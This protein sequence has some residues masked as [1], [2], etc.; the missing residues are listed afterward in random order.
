MEVNELFKPLK[1][2]NKQERDYYLGRVEESERKMPSR[3]TCR[4]ISFPTLPVSF[5]LLIIFAAFFA[6]VLFPFDPSYMALTEKSL[7]PSSQHWF[8]TDSLGRDVFGM[9]LHGARISLLIG[10]AS[11]VISMVM[12]LVVGGS[13][14]MLPGFLKRILTRFTDICLSVPSI[15]LMI[16]FQGIMRESTWMSISL[17]IGLSSWM[18]M[19]KMIRT[20][21]ERI[22]EEEY[23]LLARYYGGGLFYLLKRHFSQTLLPVLSYMS[24]TGFG[25]AITAEATL[26]FL[27]IGLPLDTITWGTL[28]H[29]SSQALMTKAWWVI[30]IPGIFLVMTVV[31]LVEIG[32]YIRNRNGIEKNV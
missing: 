12:A 26:S 5:L 3:Q 2:L 32:D 9:I 17:S 30:V 1:E 22:S 18:T 13:S 29:L 25:H 21:I 16:F 31:S 27:G 8:G 28:L 14:A 23:V 11:T 24:F 10:L 15:L 4:K 6:D 7:A 19:A 20:Q